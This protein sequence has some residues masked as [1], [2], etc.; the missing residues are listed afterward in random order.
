MLFLRLRFIFGS[1]YPPLFK[2]QSGGRTKGIKFY[3]LFYFF[4]MYSHAT[5]K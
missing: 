1:K 4:F 2:I 5:K 3:L